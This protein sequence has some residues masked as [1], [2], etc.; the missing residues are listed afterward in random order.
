MNLIRPK[1]E[2]I[3]PIIAGL[4]LCVTAWSQ[5]APEITARF[6]NPRLNDQHNSLTL[7]VELQ[8]AQP[9]QSLFGMNVRFFYD[10][11]V[12]KFH[13]FG[14]FQGGYGVLGEAPA[15]LKGNASSGYLLFHLE[16]AAAYVNSAV[17]LLNN[18][19]PVVISQEGWTRL[20]S[21]SFDIPEGLDQSEEICP[22]LIWDLKDKPGKGGF[23]KGEDGLVITV[24]NQDP[25]EKVESK[26]AR[27]SA[28]PF[29]WAYSAGAEAYPYGAPAPE[30]CFTLTDLLSSD[31]PLPGNAGGFKLY[32]NQPNPFTEITDIGFVLPEASSAVLHV[33]DAA[34]RTVKR[35]E[36]Q[37][38]AGFNS[39]RF[40]KADL[41][42]NAASVLFY[43]LETA[44][45]TSP[46]KKMSIF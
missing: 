6:A 15:A 9:G 22:S 29:N 27:V 31:L 35:V 30:V 12:L 39:V 17:Q 24:V 44:D 43:R 13:A 32:Q 16:K 34:G 33:F 7:D 3:V 28:K 38:S 8:S 46:V 1:P 25:G 36:G 23:F 42:S 41:E 2:R 26:A 40:K 19:S 10:A 20:F 4:L 21:V 5:S 37:F 11:S 14:D 18:S 45:F